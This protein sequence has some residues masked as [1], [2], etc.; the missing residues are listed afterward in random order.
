MMYSVSLMFAK[1]SPFPVLGRFRIR[2]AADSTGRHAKAGGNQ[3][4]G[5][6]EGNSL[7][8][9]EAQGAGIPNATPKQA[10][11]AGEKPE[12]TEKPRSRA[13]RVRTLSIVAIA[14]LAA[15]CGY[16]KW[17]FGELFAR[18]AIAS[19]T[20][21]ESA[22]SPSGVAALTPPPDQPLM[23]HLGKQ[24]NALSEEI[25]ALKGDGTRED[26]NAF[27]GDPSQTAI[28]S[29][30]QDDAGRV[31]EQ[32]GAAARPESAA[33]STVAAQL[34]GIESLLAELNSRLVGL[35]ED[36]HKRA[37]STIAVFDTSQA[38]LKPPA[39]RASE[40]LTG[41]VQGRKPVRAEIAA[42]DAD[43]QAVIEPLGAMQMAAHEGAD[44]RRWVRVIGPDWRRDLASGERLPVGSPGEARLWVD[45]AGVF[46]IVEFP[47]RRP[48]RLLL[49]ENS[50]E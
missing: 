37:E 8:S 48:C 25:E 30:A 45:K 16:L 32:P 29:A 3:K 49:E 13:K 31:K 19:I 35:E 33:A 34:E 1:V 5:V 23:E 50:A 42:C 22:S 44:G 36:L 28:N 20:Q 41:L 17:P 12:I 6:A 7:R 27:L 39:D 26:I 4:T 21:S 10:A 18:P 9:V 2:A 40:G 47:G 43:G 46:G 14:M 15:G 38:A 11:I 24:I